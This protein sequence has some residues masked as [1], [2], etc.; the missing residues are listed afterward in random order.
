MLLPASRGATFSPAI[1]TGIHALAERH[2]SPGHPRDPLSLRG[3][4]VPRL[5][6]DGT[7]NLPYTAGEWRPPCGGGCMPPVLMDAQGRIE[8]A[9]TK[10]L[11]L[12]VL[13]CDPA[14]PLGRT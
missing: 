4:K 8:V 9:W 13:L 5:V 3:C 2:P 11:V 10:I 7:V 12:F 6:D 14:C 1:H